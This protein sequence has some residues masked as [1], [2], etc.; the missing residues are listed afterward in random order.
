MESDSARFP[1]SFF[2]SLFQGIALRQ[3]QSEG[4]GLRRF[5]SDVMAGLTVGVIALPL[6]MALAIASGVPPQHGLYTAVVAG[7]LAALLGGSRVSVTGPTAAFVVLLAPV[8]LKFGLGGL[9]LATVMAGFI[10]VAMGVGRLGRLIQFIPYPV[11]TGFTAGIAAVIAI[12]QL[13]DFFGLAPGAMPDHTLEKLGALWAAHST[14]R[15]QDALIGALTMGILLGWPRVTRRVPPSLIAIPVG[16]FVAYGLSHWLAGFDVATIGSRFQYVLNGET[17]AGIPPIPPTFRMPWNF[18]GGD[19]TPIGLSLDV[20]QSLVMPA[21]AIAVLGS[22]ESLLCAVVADGMIG[23]KHDPDNELVAQGI[24]N[25]VAPFFGGFAATGAIAR[26]A[27]N[28][29]SGGR[30][31]WASV[32]HAAFVL[33]AMLTL[34]PLLAYLPMASL[35]ALLLVVAWNMS[36][37]KHFIHIAKIGPKSDIVVL[38]TCFSLTVVFDMVIAVTVGVVLASLLFMRRMAEITHSR[39]LDEEAHEVANLDVPSNTQI[40]E[41]AGPLFF[42]AAEKAFNQLL[43]V[44]GGDLPKVLIV[45]LHGVPAM[46]ITGLVALETMLERAR[47]H[48]MTTILAAVQSQPLKVLQKAGIASNHQVVIC[49]TLGEALER[50]RE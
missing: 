16:A 46:D 12:L 48:K 5:Q 50:A 13:K 39:M 11:T 27:A 4:Y 32:V 28:I 25:L 6:S 17:G 29:R 33:V 19:G 26:T 10:Q 15:W 18:A 31:P 35:A 41:I 24:G 36:D 9:L 49:D 22:I 38:L 23:S 40:Y 30:T 21:T 20:L 8:S 14:F 7:A 43:R 2:S 34:A 37:L 1:G 42:G 45:H 3:T 44:E 47:H